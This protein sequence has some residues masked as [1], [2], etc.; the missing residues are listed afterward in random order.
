L[1]IIQVQVVTLFNKLLSFFDRNAYRREV[2]QYSDTLRRINALEA[3]FRKLSDADLHLCTDRL[4]ERLQKGAGQEQILPEAFAA[5]REAARRTIGLRHYDVQ[6]IGGI[7]LTWGAI[8]EMRTGEGKTLVATL[9]LYLNAL[10]GEGAHLV[11]VNDYLA[12]RDARWMGP[13]YHLLGM[14]VGVLQADEPGSEEPGRRIGYLYDPDHPDAVER[15]NLLRRLSRAEAYAA[16]ITYGTNSEFGFDYLRDNLAPRLE[17]KAQRGHAFAIV[18]EVDNILIDEA[19]TPLIISGENRSEI[20]WYG[21]MAEAVRVLSPREVEINRRDQ[22]ATLTP[23]GEKHIAALLGQP[24]G[25]PN[26]PEEASLEQRHLIGHLE[27]ALRARFLYQRDK[28]YLIQDGKVVIVDEYTGRMMPGRR[29]TDGLHQAV[30]AKEGLEVQSESITYATISLQNYFRMYTRL[31]G[32]TGTALTASKEFEKIYKLQ[33]HPIPTHVEYQA[34]NRVGGLVERQGKEPDGQ[35]NIY[36][37]REDDP[38]QKPLFWRRVDYPVV[39]YPSAEAKRRAI[40]WEILQQHA[41]GRPLLVGTTSVADSEELARYLEGPLLVRLVQ[42][43]WL[44][45]A[46]LQAHPTLHPELPVEALKFLN[47]PLG[48]LSPARLENAFATLTLDPDPL[49]HLPV[50]LEL[51]GL[52]SEHRTRLETALRNGIPSVVLNARYHYEESQIIAGAGAYGSVV[53]ATNMAGRGVDIK[54]GG[55][56]AEEVLAAVNQVLEQSGMLNPYSLTL[57]E[58]RQALEKLHPAQ[59]SSR[60]AEVGYFLSYVEGMEQ[61]KE[62]GGLHVIGGTRHEARRID[63]QLRGRAARQGDPGSSRFYVSMEDELLVRF[64]G[65]EAQD[66][67][68]QESLRGGNP[69]LPCPAEA[70]R[71]LIE[72]AQNRVENENYE[73]RKHLLDYDDVINAQRLAIYK[74]RDRILEKAD[75]SGDLIEMLQAEL[76]AQAGRTLQSPA[77]QPW[78]FIAWVEGLQPGLVRLDGRLVSSWP[79]QLVKQLALPELPAQDDAAQVRL[80]LLELAGQAL[81]A[82]QR[83]VAA[84][85]EGQCQ[86]TLA[87]WQAAVAERMEAVDI[88]LENLNPGSSAIPPRAALK[89]LSAAAGLPVQLSE[90]SWR[91][92]KDTP[93]PAANETLDQVEAALFQDAAAHISAVLERLLGQAPEPD[94]AGLSS[95]DPQELL[96]CAQAAVHTA[97]QARRERLLGPQGELVQRLQSVLPEL[98]GPLGDE[99]CL[100]LLE[101]MRIPD[102]EPGPAAAP[103][104]ETTAAGDGQ[105]VSPTLRPVKPRLSYVFLADELLANTPTD[106]VAAQA[107]DSLL[108]AQQALKEDLGDRALNES[109]RALLLATIDERWV[110]YLTRL[111]ELRYEVRLE[112][113]AHND[114]LVMYKSKA[115]SAYG[116]LLAELRRAAVAQMFT[117]PISTR[118]AGTA[119]SSSLE[120]AT[121]RLTYL[122]LG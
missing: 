81:L 43:R 60:Q 52:G 22:V 73:I 56:L 64:G 59:I 113:M 57:A 93:R 27:Q 14:S 36:Y 28:E 120:K 67:L 122:K 45:R 116:A 25:D 24:L 74:Q 48:L 32:M 84:E 97:F 90:A 111:E 39:L 107:L 115:S 83:F 78:Q 8:A 104:D 95:V 4:R 68:E 82:E 77:G 108:R 88:V 10:A 79:L 37:T 53:I 86:V 71:R 55:E 72:T 118:L 89:E 70:G 20:E 29:W 44:R 69:L 19:R 6:I 91:S 16:D 40:A 15:F 5:V 7:V 30:E 49:A 11:T 117:F 23:G 2:A 9:P 33:V 65:V 99:G 92:L 13:I 96:N 101:L 103:Q 17:D 61:V 47:A 62:L 50:L 12:R 18:D 109:Y 38:Q 112:G 21:R 114:P 1:D 35:P 100:T 31:S 63:H 41:R 87:G 58:R 119:E 106:Q 94:P 46:W 98:T 26:R 80:A 85:V 42:A 121:P 102:G 51:L 34:L 54:L 76:D 110:D 66:F 3:D 105:T 75:L